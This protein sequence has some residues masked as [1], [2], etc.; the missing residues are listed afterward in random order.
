MDRG[1]AI[2]YLQR[3]GKISKPADPKFTK[4]EEEEIEEVTKRGK[5]YGDPLVE[6][7]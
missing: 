7:E 4:E 6:I 1:D 5:I 2:T 3:K